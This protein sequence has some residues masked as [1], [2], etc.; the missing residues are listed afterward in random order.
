MEDAV[1]NMSSPGASK[2]LARQLALAVA[3]ASGTALLAVPGFT[4]AA[5]AQKKKKDDK[6]EEAKPAYSEA[7]VKAYQPVDVALKAPGVDVAAIKPQI[8]ALVPLAVSP[9]EQ[10]ALGGMIFNAGISGKDMP[11]QFQ[12][13]EMMLGSGKVQPADVGKFSLVAF[14]IANALNQFDKARS[15]LQKAIDLGYSAPSTS[16]SDLQMNMAELYFSEERYTEGLKYL[17]DAIAARKAQGQPVDIR[18]YKRGVS[19]AYTNEIV[20]QVYDFVQAWVIDYPAPE[21]WRDAVNLTRNLNE[22]DGPVL[23]DLL[24]LGKK[25]GTLKDKNDYVFYVEAAD[26]RRLPIE[27][28][29]V[30]EEANASGVIPKGSDSWVEEQ[31]KLASGLVAEDRAALPVLERDA[32]A[33]AARLRTVIAA[34][35]TFLSYGEY[36]KAAGFY[37]RSLTMPEVDRNLALTRLGIAQIGAGDIDAARATFAKVEGLRGPIAMLWSAYAQQQGTATAATAVGG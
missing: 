37:E 32:N 33:P 35:D 36:A 8:L 31:Y 28:K 3:L 24:R 19:V 7:F 17:S 1:T 22:F 9:D 23:L 26:T 21:N 20:P 11:L 14:Q 13:V 4:G 2:G 10:I 27:V 34:G 30:I 18:W 5:Y 16:T 12:G 29:Q 6:K 25:V 15:Y